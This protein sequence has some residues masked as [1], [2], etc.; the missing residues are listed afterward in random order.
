MKTLSLLSFALLMA[1]TVAAQE[2]YELRIYHVNSDAQE[3]S[4]DAYLGKAYL[5]AMHKAGVAKIGVFKPVEQDT[6]DRK[7]YVL[8][9]MKNLAQLDTR[10]EQLGKDGRYRE[11]SREYIDAPFSNPPYARM[12]KIVLKAFSHHPDLREPKLK[13]PRSERVYELRSYEGH[14][15]K[16]FKNKVHMFNEG[17]EITLFNKLG[18][19]AV[20][21]GEVIAGSR[22][23]NLM[24]MTTFENKESRDAHWKAFGDAPE[25][26]KMKSLPQYQNNVSKIDIFFLRPTEY[27]DF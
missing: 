3:K 5:P 23:P 22:M 18:F 8:I 16:I 27:S 4:I 17:G 19:N 6:A 12:E 15:E 21:Y 24:Y 1:V 10:P 2:F 13:G 9:P 26:N 20:F 25:W 7:V 11:S 14:T